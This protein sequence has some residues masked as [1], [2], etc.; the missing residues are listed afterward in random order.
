MALILLLEKHCTI[1]EGVLIKQLPKHI[2]AS[3]EAI[4]PSRYVSL[5]PKNRSANDAD[6]DEA[7]SGNICRCGTYQRIRRAVHRAAQIMAKGAV[8]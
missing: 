5:L 6:G 7:M 2:H 3:I 4:N 8:G 1:N